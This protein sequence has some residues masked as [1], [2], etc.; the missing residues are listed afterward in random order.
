MSDLKRRKLDASK[1]QTEREAV[2]TRVR[3][4]TAGRC[5]RSAHELP[6]VD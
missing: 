6:A 3:P 5:R 4:L 1:M 2:K